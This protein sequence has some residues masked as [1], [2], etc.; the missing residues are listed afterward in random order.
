M[1]H[2]RIDGTAGWRIYPAHTSIHTVG[3]FVVIRCH[4][5]LGDVF[6]ERILHQLFA[7]LA[8]VVHTVAGLIDVY[9]RRHGD[10][11]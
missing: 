11:N 7:H 5:P 9:L 6:Q 2:Q 10:A 4:N 8:G 3:V 1:G